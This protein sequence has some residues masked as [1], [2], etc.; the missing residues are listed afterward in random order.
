M[1]LTAREHR[2]QEHFV[3]AHPTVPVVRVRAM[4]EDVHDLTG[5]RQIGD[6]LASA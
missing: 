3:S 5:L 4:S 6:L 1:Q 2:E